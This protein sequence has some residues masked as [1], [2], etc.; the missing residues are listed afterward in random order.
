MRRM[1]LLLLIL[2][3]GGLPLAC[4]SGDD[5]STPT[6]TQTAQRAERQATVLQQ[7]TEQSAQPETQQPDQN[8]QPEQPEQPDAQNDDA[9]TAMPQDDIG[10]HK[11]VRAQRNVLGEPDAPVL[12]EYYGDFT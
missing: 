4:G 5:A 12:I 7:E 10:E 9:L 1:A 11:G 6:A 2:S 8:S 3:L